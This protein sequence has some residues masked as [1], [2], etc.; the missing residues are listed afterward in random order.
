M[1]HHN[2][3]PT[4]TCHHSK[5]IVDIVVYCWYPLIFMGLKKMYDDI[6]VSYRIVFTALKIF[7]TLPLGLLIHVP[8]LEDL[9]LIENS[10]ILILTPCYVLGRRP[11]GSLYLYKNIFAVVLTLQEP[12]NTL[13]LSFSWSM[14]GVFSVMDKL[15]RHRGISPMYKYS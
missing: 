6:I 11:T 5:P 7:Y 2:P 15:C 4:L 10:L 8:Y 9:V 12:W 3:W 13:L 1:V 14:N